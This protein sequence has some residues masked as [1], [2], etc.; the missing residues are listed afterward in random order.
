ME[1]IF[2]GHFPC[3]ERDGYVWVYMTNAPDTRLPEPVPEVPKLAVF[4]EK[5]KITHL[6][7][8]QPSHIDHVYIGL[9]E[10]AHGPFVHQ[11]WFWRKRA[12]IHVKEKK[13]GPIP[14]GF[15]MRPNSPSTNSAPYQVL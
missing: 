12:S 1:R 4:S 10:P 7:C 14:Y 9:M 15:R 11:S 8:E 2:A 5:Y 6:C 3:E 13:F